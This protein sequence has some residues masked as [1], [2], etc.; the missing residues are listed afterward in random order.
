MRVGRDR[1]RVAAG[2]VVRLPRDRAR[3]GPAAAE[4]VSESV[5]RPS[6]IALNEARDGMLGAG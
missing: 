5:V 2:E 4:A 6:R 3:L 1:E